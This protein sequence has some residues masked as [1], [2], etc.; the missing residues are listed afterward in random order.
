MPCICDPESFW[1]RHKTNNELLVSLARHHALVEKETEQLRRIVKQYKGWEAYVKKTF[2]DS[3]KIPDLEIPKETTPWD[4][5]TYRNRS[6][7]SKEYFGAPEDFLEKEE[8][9][10]ILK[11]DNR[12]AA[13]AVN[14]LKGK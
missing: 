13:R 2:G 5:I 9:E 3:V 4:D 7:G 6:H 8:F 12:S 1:R 11:D 10:V 14:L